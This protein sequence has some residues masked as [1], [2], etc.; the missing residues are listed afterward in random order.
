MGHGKR[1]M[2][3]TL[4]QF[5]DTRA[6]RWSRHVG[7]YVLRLLLAALAHL[8]CSYG[9]QALPIFFGDGCVCDGR[10]GGSKVK[11][12]CLH[13]CI[14]QILGAFLLSPC[15]STPQSGSDFRPAGCRWL[16]ISSMKSLVPTQ[17][18]GRLGQ[19]RENKD[20]WRGLV[21]WKSEMN[22]IQV[23]IFWSHFPSPHVSPPPNKQKPRTHREGERGFFIPRI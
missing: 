7:T 1:H 14:S 22:R 12:L 8:C 15:A 9:T 11:N 17:W 16:R 4:D 5:Q 19:G 18:A 3:W 2:C 6:G 13:R 20:H 23:V 10:V 21:G